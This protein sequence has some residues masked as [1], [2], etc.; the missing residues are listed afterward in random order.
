MSISH[1]L[2]ALID[3]DRFVS[4]GACMYTIK[5]RTPTQD[6]NKKLKALC[7]FDV[8]S[9]GCATIFI[10]VAPVIIFTLFSVGIG[11]IVGRPLD[12]MLIVGPLMG[13]LFG[14]FCSIVF[15]LTYIPRQRSNLRSATEDSKAQCIQDIHVTSSRVIEIDPGND[16]EPVLA[17]EIDGNSI[18]LLKGQWLREDR[19]YGAKLVEEDEYSDKYHNGLP[20]PYSFP[21]NKFTISRF[22][23]SRIVTAIH[24]QGSYLTPESI[25]DVVHTGF[26]SA[27]G[28]SELLTGTLD[29]ISGVLS[30]VMKHKRS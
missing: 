4:L 24:V 9:C 23:N 22:P 20:A 28:D 13:G 18:L 12:E 5:S 6:E 26:E 17:F 15:L 27:L 3:I 11:W 7:R 19:I 10:C 2:K 14:L 1:N 30:R 8:R 16:L 29:D 21:S 25:Q